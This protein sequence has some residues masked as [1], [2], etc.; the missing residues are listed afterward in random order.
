[1][2]TVFFG[3]PGTA[4]PF[5]KS[6]AKEHQVMLVVSQPDREAGRGMCVSCCPVKQTAL[7]MGLEA[8]QPENP[9]EIA[10]KLRSFRP[11]IAVVVAYGRLLK[12]DLLAVPR[13]GFLNV[14][15]SL[16]PRY[17]GAAPVQRALMNGEAETGVTCFWLDEGMDTGPVFLQKK[18]NIMPEDNSSVLL[19]RLTGMGVDL[20]GEALR[21]AE[22]GVVIREPQKGIASFAPKLTKDISWM[23]FN[24]PAVVLHNK[25][26]GLRCGPKARVKSMVC[27]KEAVIQIIK[28][29]L[30]R[31]EL[32]EAVPGQI[33]RV[34]RQRGFLVKCGEGAL[35]VEEVQPE[36][37]K[38]ISG[39]DFA[40]GARLAPGQ[41]FIYEHGQ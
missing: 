31:G 29:S 17:R 2:K 18:E 22:K 36:G 9:S 32:P 3:T 40:N 6:I 1:M 16:L 12:K 41:F 19:E 24:Q 23:D 13:F 8:A 26:R 21:L 27:G 30:F 28:T 11:D 38:I 15:F 37:K 33:I 5:L 4:V 34:E 14:H 20:L 10:D 25:V 39:S 7:L 35:L